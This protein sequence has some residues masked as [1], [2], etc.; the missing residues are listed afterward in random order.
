MSDLRLCRSCIALVMAALVVSGLTAFPL[1]AELNWL[2]PMAPPG[3]LADWLLLVSEGLT[4]TNAR[5]PFLAYGT[6]WLAF[7]HLILAVLFLGPWKDPVRNRW[8]VEFGLFACVAV[9]PLALI[10][11]PL[12]GIPMFWRCIDCS[13]GVFG[14]VP[15]GLALRAIGRMEVSLRGN[16][17]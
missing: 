7:A 4:Q 15:L 17:R 2:A 13:F 9:L 1:Q 3:P 14:A 11:G 10:C 5:F 8:V 6:D 16:D 12:R